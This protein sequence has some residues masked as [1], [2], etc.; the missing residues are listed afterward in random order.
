MLVILYGMSVDYSMLDTNSI[1]LMQRGHGQRFAI[2]DVLA[3]DSKPQLRNFGVPPKFR[4]IAID[5][6]EPSLTALNKIQWSLPRQSASID[7]NLHG[8]TRIASTQKAE[9]MR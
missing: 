7:E 6:G 3:L 8:L 2:S 9:G 1:A 5:L 4:R